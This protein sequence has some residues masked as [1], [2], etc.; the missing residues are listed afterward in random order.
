MSCLLQVT[1]L[2]G[3]AAVVLVL[4]SL[5]GGGGR[6]GVGLLPWGSTKGTAAGEA[7]SKSVCFQPEVG[8][9]FSGRTL[10]RA[11]P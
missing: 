5:G 2:L 3:C 9:D 7:P 10:V 11:V 8:H 4:L 6:G 1:S